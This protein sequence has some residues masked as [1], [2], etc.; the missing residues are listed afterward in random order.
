MQI[1]KKWL[2][3]SCLLTAVAG[4]A[5]CDLG[6]E[7]P[8]ENASGLEFTLNVDG[9]SYCVSGV[10]SSKAYVLEIPSIYDGKPVTK[11]GKGAFESVY[12][13][14]EVVVPDSVVEIGENAFAGCGNLETVTV[15]NGCVEILNEAFSRCGLLKEISFGSR[16]RIPG[17]DTTSSSLFSLAT[18]EPNLTLISSACFLMIEQP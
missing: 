3:A 18:A 5:S 14:C 11:I 1:L 9:E 16:P 13:L 10:G 4:F 15:G 12:E 7:K 6:G 8:P 17:I 2:V